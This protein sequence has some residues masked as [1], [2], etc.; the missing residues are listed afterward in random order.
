MVEATN[1][2]ILV[3][4]TCLYSRI[5]MHVVFVFVIK[6]IYQCCCSWLESLLVLWLKLIHLRVKKHTCNFRS[7]E[8]MCTICRP[9]LVSLIIIFNWSLNYTHF[10]FK[11]IWSC[12]ILFLL[13]QDLCNCIF[14]ID[15]FSNG[16]FYRVGLWYDKPDSNLRSSNKSIHK[17]NTHI[18][19]CY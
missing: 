18:Y 17:K 8:P 6:R 16:A 11:C 12:G 19:Y 5:K 1:K 10:S 3:Q 13:L 4:P 9:L 15:I 14:S 2:Q 7:P